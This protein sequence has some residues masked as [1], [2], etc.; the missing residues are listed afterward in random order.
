MKQ[1]TGWHDWR[2]RNQGVAVDA[3]GNLYVSE[4]GTNTV[5][6]MDPTGAVATLAGSFSSGFADGL[7]TAAAFSNPGG[8][9]VD[10]AGFV[11]V[12]D[13]GNNAVRKISP[14]GAVRALSRTIIKKRR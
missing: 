7:G 13:S 5:R 2:A 8:I 3:S 12:A 4:S 11:Y 6:K 9:A 10:A 1:N 14:A